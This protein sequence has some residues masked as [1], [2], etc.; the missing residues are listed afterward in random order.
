ML[1]TCSS[2]T[3]P[4]GKVPGKGALHKLWAHAG[5]LTL[6][7]VASPWKIDQRRIS[8]RTAAK[9]VNDSVTLATM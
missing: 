3:R 9:A 4:G 7:R 8:R 5:A 1:T 2:G 6:S